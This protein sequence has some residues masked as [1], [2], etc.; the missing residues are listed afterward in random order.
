[1]IKKISKLIVLVLFLI[2]LSPLIVNYYIIFTTKDKIYDENNLEIINLNDN[3]N[4]LFINASGYEL[5]E[6]G[7]SSTL[8]LIIIGYL[9]LI[10]P[11][12]YIGYDIYKKKGK[13]DFLSK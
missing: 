4:I 13:A 9:L 11:V 1:M 6:T 10:G 5:P 2:V 7:S 8:I 3:S 12:I